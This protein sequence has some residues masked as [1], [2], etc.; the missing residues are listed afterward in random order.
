M[1]PGGSRASSED[2]SSDRSSPALDASGAR[3]KTITDL[4]LAFAQ[5]PSS[6]V[7]VE[8]CEAYLAKNR[9]MEAMVVCKKAGRSQPDAVEPKLLLARVHEAQGRL[10]RALDVLEELSRKRPDDPAVT[11]ALGRVRLSSGDEAGGIAALKRALDLDPAIQEAVDLL[12]ERGIAYPEPPP[13]PPAGIARGFVAPAAPG[14]GLSNLPIGHAPTGGPVDGQ[15]PGQMPPGA[16]GPSL[17]APGSAYMYGPSASSGVF[18]AVAPPVGFDGASGSGIYRIPPQLLEGEAELERLAQQVAEERPSRGRPRTT[19][20]LLAVL[21]VASAAIVGLRFANKAKVE[22]IDRLSKEAVQAFDRDLYASYKRAADALEDILET[23]EP[24]H[25]KTAARLAHVYAILLTEHLERSVKPRLEAVVALAEDR[26]P[27]DPHTVAA[28]GL[29][30]L[31]ESEDRL[32]GAAA[33]AEELARAAAAH[34]TSVPTFIDL[35]LGIAEHELGEVD[36]A[37]QRLRRVAE[38]M[39][40]NVRARVWHARAAASAGHLATAQRSFVQARKAEPRHPGA[41]AG[42]ALVTLARGNLA[43]ATEALDMFETLESEGSRD[44]SPK[45]RA[46]AIF[47]KSELLRRDANEVAA[48]VE[49]ERALRLDPGNADFPFQRGRGLLD[50]DRL[51]GAVTYL[52]KAVEMEPGRWT[53]RVELAE[54]LMLA[55][56]FEEAKQH[57]DFALDKAPSELKV[58]LA[59]ARYLR[60]TDA[61]G[62]E[63]YLV[64]ALPERFPEAKVEIGLELGRYFRAKGDLA[65]AEQQLSDAIKT[66]AGRSQTLQ[67]DV[68]V[69]YGLVAHDAGRRDEAVQA[70]RAAAR[71]GNLDALAL[72]AVLLQTGSSEER[73]EALDAGRRYLAAGKA[74]RRTDLVRSVI[75][76]LGG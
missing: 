13:P 63:A 17:A 75:E 71:R 51:E 57:L 16:S 62:A 54:A 2:G 73:A 15:G 7:F 74:L 72:L 4:E 40:N 3:R 67:S 53:F 38:F 25:P 50:R 27:G 60:R 21:L 11:A 30:R 66:F 61:P 37:H 12:E 22:A 64:E 29:L 34:E 31:A 41:I 42:L 26:A 36:S 8:L 70:Y 59:K 69:S 55:K 20:F 19:A 58:A 43:G 52:S 56:R 24:G 65:K 45:D 68:L 14:S 6:P 23:Q 49:Y 28:R 76:R 35:T 1:R 33:A 5:N 46:L 39:G 48:D 18:P 44:I 9:F 10:P 32:A 47:A